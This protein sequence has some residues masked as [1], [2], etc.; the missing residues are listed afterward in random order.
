MKIKH[1]KTFRS[2]AAAILAIAFLVPGL[3]LTANAQNNLLINGSFEEDLES[4]TGIAG[5]VVIETDPDHVAHGSK[6]VKVGPTSWSWIQQSFEGWEVGETYRF[7][8]TAKT[9]AAEQEVRVSLKTRLPGEGSD[10]DLVRH[11]VNTTD[12][13]EYTGT[14]TVP[15]GIG[16]LQVYMTNRG[17]SAIGYIDN[18][19]VELEPVESSELPIA[20]TPT[21]DSYVREDNPTRIYQTH[22]PEELQVR[23]QSETQRRYTYMKFDVPQG[24]D[25]LDYRA[26]L[27]LW[28]GNVGDNDGLVIQVVTAE[29]T[30]DETTL[31]WENRPAFI[32][33]VDPVEFPFPFSD[34]AFGDFDVDITSLVEGLEGQTVT[35]ALRYKDINTENL[36]IFS[37]DQA[38]AEKV[39]TLTF[40]EPVAV[41]GITLN[42]SEVTIPVGQ[43]FALEA[44]VAPADASNKSVTW[45]SSDD[46]IAT[47]DANGVVTAV[48]I[49]TATITVETIEG[50]FTAS[51]TVTVVAAPEFPVSGVSLAFEKFH[52]SYGD[53]IQ[54]TPIFDPEEPTD[55]SVTWS[56]SDESVA[57]VDENGLVT[58]VMLGET[59]ITVTTNDGGFTATTDIS[60]VDNLVV[61]GSFEE[62]VTEDNITTITGWTH[63]SP[64]VQLRGFFPVHGDNHLTFTAREATARQVVNDLIPGATYML[65]GFIRNNPHDNPQLLR[66]G[67]RF[68]D[69]D[70]LEIAVDAQDWATEPYEIEFTLGAD[71]DS[72]EIF[73][74]DVSG[75][76]WKYADY[77]VLQYKEGGPA[78]TGVSNNLSKLNLAYGD[79]LQLHA[80]FEPGDAA[81]QFASWESSD[82]SVATVD[83]NG[84]VT[85]VTY[86]E[87]V[88]TATSIDGGFTATT[89]IKVVHNLVV[90]GS[91]EEITNDTITG[92]THPAPE[93]Q[94]RGF[95]PLHGENHLTF[96]ARE[97][98]AV[99]EV[100]GLMPEATYVLS[101]FIRNNPHDD[102]QEIR[103]GV[104]YNENDSLV[105]AVDAQAWSTEPY[106][107]EFTLDADHNSAEVF[108][109]DVSGSGWKYADYIVLHHKE[110]GNPINLSKFHLSLQDAVQLNL[111]NQTAVGQTA[112]WSSSNEKAATVD[113]NGLVTALMIGETVISVTTNDGITA[114]SE[115]S[116]VDNL[117]VN[118]S[119]E[120]FVTEDGNTIITGWNHPA[121]EVQ[122]RGFFPVHGDNHLTFTAREATA[123]QVVNDLYPGAT[124]VLSGFIRNNPHNDP[125]LL[126]MGVRFNDNDTLEIAVD[127]QAWA[128]E[129][130]EIEFT[131]GADMDSVEIFI[132]DVSG[133]GWKY[134][135]YIVLQYKEGGPAVTGVSNNLSKLNLVYGDSFQLH[136]IYEPADAAVQFVYWESSD[137]DIVTVDHNG[138]ATAVAY[139][140]AVI[141]ATTVDGGFTATTDI[142]VV[143]NLVSNGSFEDFVTEDGNTIITGWNHPAPEVQLRGFFP[144]HGD[145]HLTFTA[146]EATATQEVTGLTPEATYV[147]SGFIRNN[148]HDN[149]QLLRMG[150]IFNDNDTLE[151]AVDAQAWATEP[152]E[153][154]FTLGADQNS[155]E[156]F[157]QDVSGSGWK[158]A[159]YIVLHHKE[160]GN[161]VTGVSLDVT[162]AQLAPG[163]TIQLH[164]TVVPAD[165]DLTT[166]TWSSSDETIATVDN[167]GLVTA[168]SY[169]DVVITVI[170]DNHSY[171]ASAQIRVHVDVT[172][173]SLNETAA[174]LHIGET[175]DLEATVAP[176]DA[177]NTDVTWTSSDDAVATVSEAGVVTA[178]ALGEAIIT[179]TTVEG[180]FTATSTIT[181]APIAVTGV[182]L[183]QTAAT[184]FVGE[185]L[186][187]EATVAPA[188]ATN[189]DVN[190]SSSDD[191]VATVSDAGVVTAVSE[192][193]ATITVTTV[194]GDFTAN[195]VVTVTIDD[196]STDD[197]SLTSL[198]VF[199][200]PVTEGKLYITNQNFGQ[201]VTVQLISVDG[202][203]VISE[204]ISDAGQTLSIDI[205][206]NIEN[207][208]YIIKVTDEN[209]NYT[210]RIIINN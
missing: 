91:F 35:L 65:S 111:V 68:N 159:D 87:A 30:W 77:I 131:L 109:Q 138:V 11:T 36:K 47:V 187:L 208:L 171:T 110:G 126:R 113:Q 71:M 59:V 88:I 124:Y 130:Y 28:G 122:L 22:N 104:R 25:G 174:T 166:V 119:F 39:P 103:M 51:A 26:I 195:A 16:F 29:N 61:N 13:T 186:N 76:G 206:R 125:Q 204:R 21:D 161:P 80:I 99:Q 72:V 168:V 135:D 69:N 163:E 94:L 180:D 164:A 31:T 49:G 100:T 89:D 123:R 144:V 205:N 176:Q 184:L 121:P 170:T 2:F 93:V 136:A 178:V 207:G 3:S 90:N 133:S 18:L 73:I 38:D 19:I 201:N 67:V 142:N 165:A 108:I 106:V 10:T 79:N 92:W 17:T 175:L 116:V 86:G 153:I 129:P 185:T 105:I 150:V 155:A 188:E 84:V 132:Q 101:G 173:V 63:P 33:N 60:V 50:E 149:P 43:T 57:T 5:D 152:Y 32:D 81:V 192:G 66:M 115:I 191:A 34:N 139:G 118:G 200:N 78:V 98:T 52:L 143:H 193:E 96:T 147:L 83:N 102:P 117:V 167:T 53:H 58:A 154:E 156:I 4:W 189:T 12:F 107:F 199:P 197:F 40:I 169:G 14:F 41:T 46:A 140:E 202:R 120:D 7:T 157:I 64:E 20:I 9:E 134:A 6:S 95:F 44:T 70:T 85:A 141:T 203:I 158:Y 23:L 145:N 196:T 75:S 1:Y 209:R 182:S 112:T 160:G 177:T 37:K 15:E 172:G 190:W 45:A 198:N 148:P 24:L 55:T 27:S 48:A 54:L 210:S 62:S 181:V 179:V 137:E 183:D 127:A 194:D 42:E 74:Q 8:I 82:E 56:S 97:A 162:T 114:T 128:T 151:I 146:R